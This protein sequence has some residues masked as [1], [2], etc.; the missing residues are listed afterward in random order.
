MDAAVYDMKGERLCGGLTP[1]GFGIYALSLPEGLGPHV[2]EEHSAWLSIDDAALGL[3]YRGRNGFGSLV[4]RRNVDRRWVLIHSG[5][6]FTRPSLAVSEMCARM[7]I[8]SP[9]EPILPGERRRAALFAEVGVWPFTLRHDGYAHEAAKWVI[10]EL[11]LALPRPDANFVSDM[12]GKHFGARL[13]EL[14]LLACFREQ[15][16]LVAQDHPSPDFYIERNGLVAFVEAVTANAAEGAESSSTGSHAPS[17]PDERLAGPMAVRFA[18]TLRSKLQRNYQQLTH[19]RGKPFA[20]AVADFSGPSSMV[21]SRE[22][23]MAY[24]FGQ[25]PSVVNTPRGQTAIA[26]DLAYLKGPQKIPAGLF[27]DPEHSGLSA[28]IF[29]NAATISKFNRMGF[30]A[31]TRLPGISMSRTGL[32]FDRA[33]NSLEPIEFCGDIL[34]PAYAALWPEGEQWTQELE[35][36]HNPLADNPF[37]KDLLPAATHWFVRDG[38]VRSEAYWEHTFLASTTTVRID[39]ASQAT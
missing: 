17:N 4:L 16:V 36:F 9:P 6:A 3:V 20:L 22:S 33:P 2:V 26:Y 32:I 25:T 39:R 15:G 19:V 1:R 28:I 38:Q 34:S 24:L 18:K 21:W 27:K 11:Y 12:R 35:V 29:S 13:W 37:P 30:L 10:E 31:G 23:L 14:Y 8:G 7:R 5:G